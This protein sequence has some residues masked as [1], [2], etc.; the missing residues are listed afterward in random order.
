MVHATTRW[1]LYVAS[2]IVLG[3]LA[4]LLMGLTDAPDGSAGT[5]IAS[6]SPVLGIISLLVG[7]ALAAGVGAL[8]A[9]RCGLRPGLICSGIVLCWMAGM[10]AGATSTIVANDGAPWGALVF[11]GVV[12]CASLLGIGVAIAI[13]A[14]HHTPDPGEH[15]VSQ[16]AEAMET[17]HALRLTPRSAGGI[18]LAVVGGAA[19]AWALALTD[20]RGQVI[21]AAAIAAIAIAMLVKLVDVKSPAIAAI[22]AAALL[23]IA[24]PAYAMVSV[25]ADQALAAAYAQSLPGLVLVMPLDWAAGALLG[26]P[27][28]LAWAASIVKRAEH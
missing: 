9:W 1:V 15:L 19:A 12:V 24:A 11:E 5:A 25:P 2:L 7:S 18:V 10:S 14:Q 8:A 26:T 22:A 23:A 27:I 4:G 13:G 20:L 16:S 21:A 3:P 17:E 6:N 28:G